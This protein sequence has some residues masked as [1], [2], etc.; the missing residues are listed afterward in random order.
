MAISTTMLESDF[1][2]MKGDIAQ[3]MTFSG[4]TR[5]VVVSDITD[6]DELA[7]A[8]YDSIPSL[9]IV[10]KLS[11]FTTS[12]NVGSQVSTGGATY[13]VLSISNSPDGLFRT[14][15]CGGLSK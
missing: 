5:S 1:D 9:S 11:D 13:R 4:V 15:T 10:F 8:G 6:S 14:L 12:P 7:I 3:T 2:F